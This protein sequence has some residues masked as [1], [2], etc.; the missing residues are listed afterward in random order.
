MQW[1]LPINFSKLFYAK[2]L[3]Y[4]SIYFFL[5]PE[6][7]LD[8]SATRNQSSFNST[9][10]CSNTDGPA[11]CPMTTPLM[12]LPEVNPWIEI[13]L[14]SAHRICQ[15]HLEIT[16]PS[17]KKKISTCFQLTNSTEPCICLSHI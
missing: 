2:V 8:E 17:G 11:N 4:C 1:N 9:D 7:I 16:D 5:F 10:P 13:Q 12:T 3:D 14:G 6:I 15:I